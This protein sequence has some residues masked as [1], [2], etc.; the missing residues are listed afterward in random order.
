MNRTIKFR[1]WDKVNKKWIDDSDIAINQQGLLFIRYE[2]QV[3]FNSMSLTKSANYEIVFFTGL[4][5]KNGKEI[6]EG[7]I[8]KNLVS[9]GILEVRWDDTNAEYYSR[10]K[11]QLLLKYPFGKYGTENFEII[12]NIYQNP[13]LVK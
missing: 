10:Y 7:D 9:K 12:G 6:Y 3:V 8:L 13:N 11:K 1:A 5:D 2:G 4:K